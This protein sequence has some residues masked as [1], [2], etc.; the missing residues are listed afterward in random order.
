[1][2]FLNNK[3]STYFNRSFGLET[4]EF[5][6]GMTER[7]V[8]QIDD[9]YYNVNE[10]QRLINQGV[11]VSSFM[12]ANGIEPE[13]KRI[14]KIL[15]RTCINKRSFWLHALTTNNFSKILGVPL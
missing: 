1:M 6:D 8:P 3:Q 4:S 13:K 10:L 15:C 7:R 11:D 12:V 2:K 14:G 5:T 9:I